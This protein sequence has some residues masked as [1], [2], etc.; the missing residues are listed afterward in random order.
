MNWIKMAAMF[1]I[2]SGTALIIYQVALKTDNRQE[3]AEIKSPVVAKEEHE[4]DTIA[5]ADRYGQVAP[6]VDSNKVQTGTVITQDKLTVV[7]PEKEIAG[8][9]PLQVDQAPDTIKPSDVFASAEARKQKSS[10]ELITVPSSSRDAPAA[11]TSQQVTLEGISADQKDNQAKQLKN[12]RGNTGREDNYYRSSNTFRG[13]VTDANNNPVPFANVTNLED[14]VGTYTDA[15]GYFNLTSPDSALYVQV[16]SLG[17]DINN[18][19]LRNVANNQVVLHEDRTI[20]PMVLNNKKPNATMRTQAAN[21]K[22]EEPEPEDGWD[23]YD[24]YLANNL[25]VPEDFKVKQTG[26]EEVRVSFEVNKLGE[27]I[28]IKVEKSLCERCDQEAIRLVREG[29]K[30]KRKARKGRTT[31]TIS[32]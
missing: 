11:T 5:A 32:F 24:S 6:M 19:Q 16:R 20:S 14:N 12:A 29:P 25:K 1:V 17:Y 4:S 10:N 18:I 23:K 9:Q 3:V 30:W 13:R 21:M 8:K 22:L 2:I 31:V 7:N 27:P 15:R 26:V 28:N